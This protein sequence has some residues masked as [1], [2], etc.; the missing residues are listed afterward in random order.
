MPAKRIRPAVTIEPRALDLATA[1][2]VYSFSE[3]TLLNLV[4]HHGFPCLRVGRR[5]VIPVAQADAW[6]AD[7]ANGT[8]IEVAG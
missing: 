3:T 8:P 5:I 4:E 7:R 6:L 1:A 2:S